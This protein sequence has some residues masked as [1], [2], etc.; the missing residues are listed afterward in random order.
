MLLGRKV[1]AKEYGHGTPV[2]FFSSKLKILKNITMKD[3]LLLRRSRCE[4]EIYGS[5]ECEKLDFSDFKWN[6]ESY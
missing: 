1:I 5:K 3:Y 6:K 2:C 4:L